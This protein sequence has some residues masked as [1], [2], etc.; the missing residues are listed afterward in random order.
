LRKEAQ[1][2]TTSDGAR[3]LRL[4]A[5][6][7]LWLSD[8][9]AGSRIPTSEVMLSNVA[10]AAQ[11][12]A[13]HHRLLAQASFSERAY[14][15]AGVNLRAAALNADTALSFSGMPAVADQTSLDQA[16]AVATRLATGGR[17]RKLRDRFG[18][19]TSGLAVAI[20]RVAD[21]SVWP[22]QRS[23]GRLV[24]LDAAAG[25]LVVET[26]NGA[27][28]PHFLLATNAAVVGP[29]AGMPLAALRVG[30]VLAV[31]YQTDSPNVA[32]R[33]ISTR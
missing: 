28:G 19:A 6:D 2:A 3:D 17:G 14:Q 26:E 27:G 9:L 7:L 12:L 30:D 11:T 23:T 21:H 22:Y 33:V 25:T 8:V 18:T 13:Q 15:R 31:W 10:M 24:E 20:A 4:A 29:Q 16:M 5:N 32:E 1:V